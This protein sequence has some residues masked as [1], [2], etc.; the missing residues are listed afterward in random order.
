M[1]LSSLLNVLN[2]KFISQIHKNCILWS[3]S[4]K[5]RDAE[6]YN[7]QK[8]IFPYPIFMIFLASSFFF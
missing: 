6:N 2:I 4:N 7:L 1:V 3:F 5:S 8:H